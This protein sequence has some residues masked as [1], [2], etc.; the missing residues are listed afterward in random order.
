MNCVWA[1]VLGAVGMLVFLVGLCVWAARR[2]ERRI[3][4]ESK[5]RPE[6]VRS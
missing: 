3:E 2:L 6:D 4:E 1:A 5:A